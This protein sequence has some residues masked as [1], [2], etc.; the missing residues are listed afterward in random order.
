MIEQFSSGIEA[1]R[2]AGGAESMGPEAWLVSVMM[3]VSEFMGVWV[4][5]LRLK[6]FEGFVFPKIGAEEKFGF[7]V[8]SEKVRYNRVGN[9]RDEL[10]KALRRRGVEELRNAECAEGAQETIR[11]FVGRVTASRKG[12]GRGVGAQ[13]DSLRYG[14]VA[15]CA[16]EKG[17]N[18]RTG[19][20]AL[21]CW[22]SPGSAG[23][24]PGEVRGARSEVRMDL[25]ELPG[26]RHAETFGDTRM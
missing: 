1:T 9:A 26:F 22:V 8:Q 24:R 12:P 16:T 2:N 4:Q 11:L 19:L 17:T 25:R 23:L 10:K 5:G 6:G 20:S 14:R 3:V 21:R 18:S 13:T 15:L 7:A